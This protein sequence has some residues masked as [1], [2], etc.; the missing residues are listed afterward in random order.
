MLYNQLLPFLLKCV[1][2]PAKQAVYLPPI[3]SAVFSCS[4][5]V[6][7]LN[8]VQLMSDFFLLFYL[9]KIVFNLF[10]YFYLNHNKLPFSAAF[11]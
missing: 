10:A 2:K 4:V 7:I 8:D 1:P 11:E 5:T 3:E 6:Y 9:K